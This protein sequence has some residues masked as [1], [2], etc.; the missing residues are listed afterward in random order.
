MLNNLF[1]F[2]LRIVPFLR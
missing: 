1:I 2:F